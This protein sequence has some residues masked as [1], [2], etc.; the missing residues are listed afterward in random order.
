MKFYKNRIAS[1]LNI[2]FFDIGYNVER[3]VWDLKVIDFL[4]K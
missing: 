1:N 3:Y 2:N 4:F